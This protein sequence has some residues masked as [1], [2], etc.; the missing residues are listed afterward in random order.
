[1]RAS[2]TGIPSV[3]TITFPENIGVPLPTSAAHRPL[4]IAAHPHTQPL[5]TPHIRAHTTSAHP[6]LHTLTALQRPLF[7]MPFFL[8]SHPSPS[9]IPS[10]SFHL[11]T[12]VHI[13]TSTP[14]H[15]P[16]HPFS[17]SSPTNSHPLSHPLSPHSHL[18]TF[19]TPHHDVPSLN[20][21]TS[22]PSYLPILP[23]PF[24]SRAPAITDTITL[25]N[26]AEI[27][28]GRAP[29]TTGHQNTRQPRGTKRG[30]CTGNNR[31]PKHSSTLR[32]Q[33]QIVLRQQ[34]D[35]KTLVNLAEPNAGRA[36]ATTGH[37]NTHQP[38]GNK[39]GSCPSKHRQWLK[40]EEERR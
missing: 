31:T 28:A 29:A 39:R 2:T 38:C 21:L 25:I 24:I 30:S 15:L 18:S 33:T 35:T 20:V 40:K 26:L 37:R 5:C 32:K 11:S 1:M 10:F 19:P 36:P 34:P 22:P 27:N 13:P 7:Q 4:F 3:T 9:H 16:T 12:S 8:T 6:P 17:S 14:S 23:P